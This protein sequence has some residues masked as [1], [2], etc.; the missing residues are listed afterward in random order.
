MRLLITRPRADADRLAEKLAAAGHQAIIS[1]LMCIRPRQVALPDP[2]SLPQTGQPLAALAFTSANGARTLAAR[3]AATDLMAVDPLWWSV[4]AY[5]VGPQTAQA[6][7]SA[8]WKI[9]PQVTGGASKQ[10]AGGVDTF[11]VATLAAN[12]LAMLHN[13]LHKGA[14]LHLAGCHQVGNLVQKLSAGGQAAEKL[15]LYEAR[16]VATL[17]REAQDALAAGKCDAVMLYSQRSAKR[18]MQ[19]FAALSISKRPLALCLSPAIAALLDAAGFVT[20]TAA[21]SGEG[22]MLALI[23]QPH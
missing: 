21:T 13:T 3:L 16:T 6:A 23:N 7:Q 22:D 18:F 2:A 17:T 10:V 9:V 4:P 19:V 14:V 15:V 8:G 11:D 12:I 20:R 1:P 5:A